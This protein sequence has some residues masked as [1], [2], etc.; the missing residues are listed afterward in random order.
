V[1]RCSGATPLCAALIREATN[2]NCFF[3]IVLLG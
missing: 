3:V 2:S 1:A